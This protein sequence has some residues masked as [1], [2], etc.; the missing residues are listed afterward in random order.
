M[1]NNSESPVASALEKLDRAVL[2]LERAADKLKP[3]LPRLVDY[4]KLEQK[5]SGSQRQNDIL[6]EAVG[7]VSTRLDHV[8]GRISAALK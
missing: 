7:R 4:P 1:K 5:L 3:D 8:I 6:R 2:R